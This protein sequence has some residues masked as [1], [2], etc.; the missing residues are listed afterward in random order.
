MGKAQKTDPSDTKR[1]IQIEF[2][3]VCDLNVAKA[4]LSKEAGKVL[5]Y[6]ETIRLL[7]ERRPKARQ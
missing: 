3:T 1:V 2:D 7:L 5:T 6:D 4:E